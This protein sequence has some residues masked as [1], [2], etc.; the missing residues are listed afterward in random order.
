MYK[1][2]MLWTY[3]AKPY[4]CVK[5]GGNHNTTTCTKPSDTPAKCALC[6]G[7]HPASYKGCEVYNN[8][9]K[10]RGKPVNQITHRPLQQRVNINDSN[11][12]PPIN[13]NQ[14]QNQ[15]TSYSQVLNQNQ[16]SHTIT[17]QF[18]AFI[19]EFKTMFNQLINENSM[20]LSLLNT[21]INKITTNG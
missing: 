14:T 15:Q 10:T 20:I 1:M 12:F 19:T 4:A 13:P 11:Q 18:S 21:V 6:E 9:Q 17:N 3:C 7:N 5:C 2:S 8:Q 16:Q